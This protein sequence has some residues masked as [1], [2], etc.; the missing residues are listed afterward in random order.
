MT[1]TAADS[2]LVAESD[3]LDP[4]LAL[5]DCGLCGKKD[6]AIEMNESLCPQCHYNERIAP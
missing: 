2:Y 3:V 5:V 4:D 6:H 1:I